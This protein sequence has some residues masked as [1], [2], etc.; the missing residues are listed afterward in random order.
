MEGFSAP[1]LISQ[2]KQ[3]EEDT[4]FENVAFEFLDMEKDVQSS[5]SESEADNNE[6][7]KNREDTTESVRDQLLNEGILETIQQYEESNEDAALSQEDCQQEN[8][9]VSLPNMNVD[10]TQVR[11]VDLRKIAMM[12]RAAGKTAYQQIV[13][14]KAPAL[15]PQLMFSVARSPVRRLARL[16][17]LKEREHLGLPVDDLVNEGSIKPYK[18]KRKPGRKPKM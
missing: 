18:Y 6:V 2:I 14:G 4:G 12:Q 3:E 1:G 11:G 10:V 5:S 9:V 7:E 15:H 17:E 13:A 16:E 8:S